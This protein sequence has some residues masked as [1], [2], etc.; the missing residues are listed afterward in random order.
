MLNVV[1]SGLRADGRRAVSAAVAVVLGVAFLAATLVL[2]DTLRAGF[3]D[4][5][6]AG[7]DGVSVVVR[8][9]DRL[10]DDELAL[11]LGSVPVALLDEIEALDEVAGAA[12]HVEGRAQILDPAGRPLGGDGP[13]TIASNW[14]DDPR[15]SPWELADGR[16]PADA[17]EVVIDR[18]SARRAG[19]SVGDT[20]TVR[21]PDPIAVTVVGIATFAGEDSQGPVTHTL[22]DTAT[23]QDLFLA[24]RSLTTTIRVAA[25]SG[26]DEESVAQLVG[27]LLPDDLEVITGTELSAEQLAELEADF[28]GFVQTMLLAFAAIGLVVATLTIHNTFAIVVAQ[29]SRQAGLLRAIGATRRQ[30]LGAVVAEAAVVGVLASAAGVSAGIG[31]AALAA[32]GM[33]AAGFVIPGSLRWTIDSLVVAWSVGI[34]ATLAAVGLPAL[35]ATRVAPLTAVRGS[36]IDRSSSSAARRVLGAVLGATSVGALVSTAV[37]D[38][39]SVSIAGVG[40]LTAVAAVIVAG[41]VLARPV[42]SVLGWPIARMRGRS[43]VLAR[44]NAVRNP[45]RTAS[46]ASSLMIG[47][48]VVVFFATTAHSLTAYIDRTV[49]AQFAGDLVIEQDG[50][51][52]PGLPSTLTRRLDELPETGLVVPLAVGVVRSGDEVLY[53]TVT[54]PSTL[55]SLIDLDLLEGHLDAVAD[56]GVA[57]SRQLAD[58]EGWSLGQ[59]VPVRVGGE[60]VDLRVSAVFGSRD[61]IGDMVIAAEVWERHGPAAPTRVVLVQR[62]PGIDL[63]RVREAVAATSAVAAAPPPLDRAEYVDR[64]SGEIDQLI[65]VMVALL[66]VAV[67]IAV[68]GI[69]NTLSLAVHERT[70]ELG[71]LRAVGMARSA[72]RSTVRWESVIVATSGTLL[73]L[74]VG[75]IG[76]WAAI[77]VFGSA[78]A[79]DIGLVVPGATF[80]TI[81]ALGAAA[82]VLAATRPARRAARVDVLTALAAT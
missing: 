32:W 6:A 81:G 37:R 63:D 75:T 40:V 33:D 8:S 2:G 59:V 62:A 26:A 66:G 55:G 78:E 56:S 15:L 70:R 10:G 79:I 58:R 14:I 68:L 48:A 9:Q 30:V 27:H 42:A 51:S 1:L 82:G 43:G 54:D 39:V 53:P 38:D 64:V 7:N 50:F 29:R 20:A 3:G 73:G 77:R 44:R 31:L 61:L 34:V 57:V 5:F 46:T 45:R 65:A 11:D 13:P 74:G 47:V 24:D 18:S 60:Q 71:L 80:A 19:Y 72:V 52:G 28:L 22:F 36:S 67:L 25:T 49:D 21:T 12:L 17:S 23:A 4:A 69:G 16:P 35:H 76:A 41:P